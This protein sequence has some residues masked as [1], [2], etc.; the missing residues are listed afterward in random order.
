MKRGY[1]L[2]VLMVVL[3]LTTHIAGYAAAKNPIRIG[4]VDDPGVSLVVLAEVAG[5]YKANGLEVVLVPFEDAA[6]GLV[7][8]ETGKVSLGAF[9]ADQALGRVGT[10]GAISI[11]AGGG[12]LEAQG[13]MGEL[14]QE[15]PADEGKGIVIVT[16]TGPGSPDKESQVRLVKALIQAY[17][18]LK[19]E[20]L[21]AWRQI[22][23]LLALPAGEHTPHLDP[24]PDFWR[25]KQIWTALGLQKDGMKRDYLASHVNEEIYCDALDDLLDADDRKD[26]VLLKLSSRAVCVPDCCPTKKKKP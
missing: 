7:A 19:K 3:I 1:P 8:L 22:G 16:A 18:Y 20:P 6:Q 15:D 2:A 21:Q 10:G 12:R 9:P 23:E 17:Q 25:L 4:Y 26:P 11:I 5:L 24:G 14:D 13:L